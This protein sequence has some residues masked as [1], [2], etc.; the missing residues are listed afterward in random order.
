[1]ST[2]TLI[3]S[4][5]PKGLKFVS[6]CRDA[7]DKAKLD[8]GRAQRLNENG[9]EFQAGLREL[10]ARFSVSNQFAS[11]EVASSYAYPDEYRGP[12]PI[13]EQVDIL[14][15][16]FGLSPGFTSDFIEKQLPKLALPEGVDGWFAIPSLDAVAKRFFPEV[17][18]PA[19][20]YCR[21]VNLLLEKLGA[22]A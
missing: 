11:E 8:D 9:G 4:N 13:G 16:V 14:A 19:E 1:M 10:I 15:K 22:L 2:K 12:K 20:R 17:T 5:D 18:D 3:T 7:Y 21:A 6:L